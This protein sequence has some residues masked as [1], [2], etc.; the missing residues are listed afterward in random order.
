MRQG[1]HLGML[2]T[3]GHHN[4]HLQR[5]WNKYGEAAFEFKV[6]T[7]MPEA[8]P[9]EL[10]AAEAEVIRLLKPEFNVVQSDMPPNHTGVRR[11][12]E[13]RAKI[14]IA[15]KGKPKT[16]E[17]KAAVSRAKMGVPLSEKH[18]RAI[19]DAHRGARRGPLS[20]ETRA[21]IAAAHLGKKRGPRSQAFKDHMS[22]LFRGKT[23]TQR[24]GGL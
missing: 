10:V 12:P 22:R 15:L 7:E 2:R 11:S 17:H 1:E 23:M 3:G 24:R 21:K 4:R 6:L 18:K 14:S 13:T 9:E 16:D 8:S 20:A 19:G 5:S